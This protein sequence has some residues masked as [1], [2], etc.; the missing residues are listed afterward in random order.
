VTFLTTSDLSPFATIDPAKAQAMIEDAEAQATLIAPCITDLA[1]DS[2]GRAAVKAILRG[3]VLRWNEAGTGALQAQQSGPYGITFDN[4]QSRRA[5]F[6]P[7]EIADLQ[8]V[9]KPS[10][11]GKAFDVDT[12]PATLAGHAPFCDLYFGGTTCSCGASLTGGI[13]PLWE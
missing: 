2:T 5:M 3:A 4:R 12:M 13:Y 1:I 6:W 9:C 11:N 7:S 10:G 8:G